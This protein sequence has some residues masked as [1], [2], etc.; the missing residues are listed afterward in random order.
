MK[1]DNTSIESIIE[2]LRV[3]K[4]C[5]ISCLCGECTQIVLE[6]VNKHYDDCQFIINP[7]GENFYKMLI[8]R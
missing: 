5:N 1:E 6:T 4:I 7:L 8:A 3:D 2:E